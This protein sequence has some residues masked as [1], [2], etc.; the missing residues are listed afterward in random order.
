MVVLKK[1]VYTT[2]LKRSVQNNILKTT[3]TQRVLKKV[4]GNL[5]INS[6]T[7][8]GLTETE[9]LGSDMTGAEGSNRTYVHT[10]TIGPKYA[11]Y[12]GTADGGLLRVHPSKLSLSTTTE[13]NDTL[14]IAAYVADTDSLVLET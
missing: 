11:V 5:T 12:L 4:Q 7:V 3:Q 6:T 14:T 9:F 13:S 1:T 2:V 10:G 8:T